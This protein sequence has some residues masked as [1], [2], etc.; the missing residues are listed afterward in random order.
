MAQTTSRYHRQCQQVLS[1]R[2]RHDPDFKVLFETGKRPEDLKHIVTT[3]AFYCRN[4]PEMVYHI[5]KETRLA[6]QIHITD[7]LKPM[8]AEACKACVECQRKPH[9]CKTCKKV[10]K[11]IPKPKSTQREL[12]VRYLGKMQNR[13]VWEVDEKQIVRGIRDRMRD[14]MAENNKSKMAHGAIS[15]RIRRVVRTLVAEKQVIKNMDGTYS[16]PSEE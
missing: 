7:E 1:I 11:F 9:G 16:L 4:D 14:I 5:V 6:A 15:D 2:L 12:V 8:I 3:L 10:A 13:G